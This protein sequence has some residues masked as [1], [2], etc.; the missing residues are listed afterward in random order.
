MII[1]K[2]M[3]SMYIVIVMLA[4]GLYMAFVQ[5]RDLIDVDHLE[6]EGAFTK[7]IGY[8]YIGAALAGFVIT[9]L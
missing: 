1:I 8:F 6:R 5:S 3:F 2:N 9:L 7:I 4:I